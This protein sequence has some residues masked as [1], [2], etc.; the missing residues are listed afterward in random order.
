VPVSN[1][2]RAMNCVFTKPV[3]SPG[4]GDMVLNGAVTAA[5]L[6]PARS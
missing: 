1:K 3:I 6:W 5:A 4:G 2:G